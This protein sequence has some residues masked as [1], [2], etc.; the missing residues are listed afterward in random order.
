ML[1]LLLAGN[2]WAWT[3]SGEVVKLKLSGKEFCD[4]ATYKLKKNKN[5]IYAGF[6][7][8]QI[9]LY[10]YD[11][12]TTVGSG[13]YSSLF[14]TNTHGVPNKSKKLTF[15]AAN[16]PNAFNAAI[17]IGE[18]TLNKKTGLVKSLKASILDSGQIYS[19]PSCY[20]DAAGSGNFVGKLLP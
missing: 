19:A 15:Y 18:I 5:V 16:T 8:G 3:P 13:P 4:G 10:T 6:F 12:T 1:L 20:I 17:M 14:L 9:K 11:P 7:S 2:S